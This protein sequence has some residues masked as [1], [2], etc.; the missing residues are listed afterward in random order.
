MT[1]KHLALSLAA[2][3]IAL[4]TQAKDRDRKPPRAKSPLIEA[5]DAN[6]DG[7]ISTEEI[8]NAAAALQTLDQDGDGALSRDEL[9]PQHRSPERMAER[10]MER[11]AN[12]DGVISGDE[13]PQF[14]RQRLDHI[15]ANGDGNIDREEALA[16]GKRKHR[17]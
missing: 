2:L 6:K 13:I 10:L 7:S 17:R 9:R 14:L 4:S 3:L 12:G 16:A 11:D 5:L 15:D 8:T 1:H